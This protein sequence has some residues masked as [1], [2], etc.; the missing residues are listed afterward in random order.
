MSNSPQKGKVYLI[1]TTLGETSPLEVLPLSVKKI[2]E[3]ID[4]YI[5]E[6]EKSARGFIKSICPGKSQPKLIISLLNKFTDP[7]E[8]PDFLDPCL[9][10]NDVGIISEAGC[11]GIADPGAEIVKLAHLKQ[12]KVIPLV[13]PS[14]MLLAMMASGMNGQSFAFN[15]YLPIDKQQRKKEI[16]RLEKR[17]QV[18]NQSQL[19]IETPYRN[20]A[21]LS[22]LIGALHPKTNVCVACDITLPTEMIQT[23]T[24]EEWK[25]IKVDLHKRPTLFIFHKEF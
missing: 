14:S 9:E 22:D 7:L 13:G 3:Q 1:P 25:K 8:I 19:F 11:P 23:K 2:I 24:V 5:V 16:K 12:I 18:E 20:D 15:G 21:F 4:F 10:G 17:S 6:N